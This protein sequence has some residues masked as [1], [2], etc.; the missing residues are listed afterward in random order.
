[1]IRKHIIFLHYLS[2][3]KNLKTTSLN[4]G[5]RVKSDRKVRAVAPVEA[6]AS[7]HLRRPDDRHLLGPV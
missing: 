4:F 7:H 6:T 2:H 3:V 5:Q 1:M